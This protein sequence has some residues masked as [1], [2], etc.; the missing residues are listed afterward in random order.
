MRGDQSVVSRE[1]F[2]NF[3][4]LVGSVDDGLQVA[5]TD[6]GPLQTLDQQVSTTYQQRTLI[7]Q[8]VTQRVRALADT[9]RSGSTVIATKPVHR[10][11]ICPIVYD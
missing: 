2:A 6:G 1:D 3:A 5:L 4:K 11:Q 10:L 9:S 8:P 7:V